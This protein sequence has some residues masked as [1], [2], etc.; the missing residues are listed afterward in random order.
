MDS[1]TT[2]LTFAVT[3]GTDDRESAMGAALSS[4]WRTILVVG[5]CALVC[6]ALSTADVRTPSSVVRADDWMTPM[7]K[8]Y[9]A[10]MDALDLPASVGAPSPDYGT[11]V[12]VSMAQTVFA[13]DPYGFPAISAVSDIY[14]SNI[15]GVQLDSPAD[16]SALFDVIYLAKGPIL[17]IDG[18]DYSQAY[19]HCLDTS[20]YTAEVERYRSEEAAKYKTDTADIVQSDNK[21]R[22][23]SWEFANDQ[24]AACARNQ[25]W[26]VLESPDPALEVDI[27]SSVSVSQLRALLKVCP[28]FDADKARSVN[29]WA[30]DHNGSLAD[31]PHPEDMYDPSIGF[32]LS[33]LETPYL[34]VLFTPE[35]RR[36]FTHL[37]SLYKVLNEQ[38]TNYMENSE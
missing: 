23:Y 33:P 28:N 15:F 6:M 27:P 13:R 14:P 22:F 12:T 16:I 7:Q 29:E 10:C 36:F 31:Y 18:V 24:W 32:R 8:S 26:I 1:S 37:I 35:A 19:A 2:S 30:Q 3:G 17:V 21:E 20:G 9:S 38:R 4:K 34:S 25:G 5:V 11:S